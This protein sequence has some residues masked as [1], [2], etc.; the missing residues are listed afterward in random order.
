MSKEIVAK[1]REVEAQAE[2]IK[3]D[4]GEE[5]KRRVQT[6]EIEGKQSFERE[7]HKIESLNAE[8]IEATKNKSSELMQDIRDNAVSDAEKMRDEAEF[9]MREAI[10][11]IVSGVTQQCQ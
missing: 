4:A 6:A 5:A 10:R 11:F 3:K 8:R 7:V 1:I 2:K 9:N